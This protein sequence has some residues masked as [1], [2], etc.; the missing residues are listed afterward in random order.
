MKLQS[1]SA[2]MTPGVDNKDLNDLRINEL[3]FIELSNKL[4]TESYQS[5]PTK[6]VNIPKAGGKTR[7]LEIPVIEDRIVQQAFL[8]LLETVFE[9]K[10]SDKSH[11]FRPNKG[12]H[13]TC[14]NIR[15]WKGVS[16]FIKGDIVNY[17]DT[18]NHKKLI[19]I[20]N[21]EI[22]NQQVINLLWKIPTCGRYD[23]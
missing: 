8:F 9:K 2:S 20:I 7:P 10:F 13:T 3:C 23:K 22:K 14:K 15:Q 12:A 21:Q 6:R 16:W 17:F 18:I 5:K 1:N 11:G 4:K 19:E